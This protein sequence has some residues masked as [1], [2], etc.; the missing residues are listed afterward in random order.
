MSPPAAY[1]TID[2]LGMR[3]RRLAKEQAE[4]Q[5]QVDALE[6]SNAAKKAAK[7]AAE[8]PV[9]AKEEPLK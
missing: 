1:G 3:K 6:A 4:L 7:L 2:L 8:G 9:A 5:A